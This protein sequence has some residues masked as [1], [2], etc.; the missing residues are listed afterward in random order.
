MFHL[1]LFSR[2]PYL[3]PSFGILVVMVLA[4]LLAIHDLLPFRPY[5]HL[6]LLES[7]SGAQAVHRL[8]SAPTVPGP[9]EFRII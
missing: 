1:L 7:A 6:C 4:Y 8:G 5:M 3:S 2:A 9:V